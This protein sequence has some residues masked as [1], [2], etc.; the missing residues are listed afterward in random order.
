MGEAGNT[1]TQHTHL[2][3]SRDTTPTHDSPTTPHSAKGCGEQAGK[4]GLLGQVAPFSLCSSSPRSRERMWASEEERG[5]ESKNRVQA[6]LTQSQRPGSA[7]RGGSD[8]DQSTAM[9]AAHTSTTGSDATTPLDFWSQTAPRDWVA[10]GMCFPHH[11]DRKEREKAMGALSSALNKLAK[12]R[13]RYAGRLRLSRYSDQPGVL[14]WTPSTGIDA[15]FKD[16]SG[17]IDETYDQLRAKG[18]PA[19]FFH[20]PEVFMLG[21]NP[22]PADATQSDKNPPAGANGVAAAPAAVSTPETKHEVPVVAIRGFFIKG[23]LILQICLHHAFGDGYCMRDFLEDFAAETRGEVLKRNSDRRKLHLPLD[24]LHDRYT[25]LGIPIPR[26]APREATAA[27][28]ASR[29]PEYTFDPQ[30]L[31]GPT[32]PYRVPPP[33]QE[34]TGCVIASIGKVKLDALRRSLRSCQGQEPSEY[35]ALS[36]LLWAYVTLHR[37]EMETCREKMATLSN[38]VNWKR[39]LSHGPLIGVLD[40]YFGNATAKCLTIVERSLLMDAARLSSAARNVSD[41]GLEGD[42][43]LDELRGIAATIRK[44]INAVDEAFVALR[45]GL[46]RALPDPRN[47]GL[48]DDP[49]SAAYMQFNTWKPFGADAKFKIPGV[50][51]DPRG[52]GG[53]CAESIRK[54]MMGK[55]F[56]FRNVLIMPARRFSDD[57]EILISLPARSLSALL[58]DKGFTRWFSIR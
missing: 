27:L 10:Y 6:R 31:T 25:S 55:Q 3:S 26:G 21:I 49:Y 58:K 19:S 18:F 37:S 16:V 44:N 52:P 56:D 42:V 9:G 33:S 53:A 13:P 7:R 35:V 51:D 20:N 2:L 39:N 5:A 46:Y 28:L 30:W 54:V 24:F 8:M 47:L 15:K 43:R 36:T 11:G 41:A 23:G 48:V 40:D 14:L 57:T 12:D 32:Q 29:C 17:E 38:P 34:R 22:N 1:L 45:T 4:G 50:P